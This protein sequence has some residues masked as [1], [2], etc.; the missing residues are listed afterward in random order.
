MR[1]LFLLLI[2]FNTLAVELSDFEFY[3]DLNYAKFD[4]QWYGASAAS[5]KMGLPTVG[6]GIE[7]GS[8]FGFRLGYGKADQV[9]TN[10]S[11]I[12]YDDFI[13]GLEKYNEFEIY[14]RYRLNA[15]Y[16]VYGGIGHYNQLVPIYKLDGVTLVKNDSDDDEGFFIGAEY[17]YKNIAANL[18]IKQTSRIGDGKGFSE[19]K[20]LGSTMRQIG[21]G[22]RFY[23]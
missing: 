10:K 5:F 22:V 13:I 20:A 6:A 16:S 12:H 17:R 8:G 14:Y 21:V 23:F 2:S 4:Y 3:T 15:S 1:G 9:R 18:F 11:S 19:S 7:H